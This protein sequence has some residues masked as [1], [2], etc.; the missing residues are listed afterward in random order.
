MVAPEPAGFAGFFSKLQ[1]DGVIDGR[2][3]ALT[4]GT[5]RGAITV[6]DSTAFAE[7]FPAAPS[8]A[9]ATPHFA[10]CRL[11]IADLAATEALLRANGVAVHREGPAI[12]IGPAATFG[13]ILEL[14]D[15][16]R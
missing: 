11:R 7:R 2:G 13:V 16:A 15:A 9:T 10:A 6:L 8:P 12:Q 4:V 14:A 1:P 3:T 5:A